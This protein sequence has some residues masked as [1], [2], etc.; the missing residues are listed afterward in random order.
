MQICTVGFGQRCSATASEPSLTIIMIDVNSVW[1]S[2]WKDRY[3]LSVKLSQRGSHQPPRKYQ[4]CQK[5]KHPVVTVSLWA[6]HGPGEEGP[7]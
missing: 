3:Y 4:P 5:E 2:I 1:Q 7:H 6:Q